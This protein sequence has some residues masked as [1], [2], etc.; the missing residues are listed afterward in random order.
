[1]NC[2]NQAG[3]SFLGKPEPERFIRCNLQATIQRI[4]T[5]RENQPDDRRRRTEDWIKT[6]RKAEPFNL[7]NVLQ[8]WRWIPAESNVMSLCC[9]GWLGFPSSGDS[10]LR[11]E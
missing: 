4:N 2:M 3:I 11:S 9:L 6:G 8:D 1:M 5:R 7:G 10:S